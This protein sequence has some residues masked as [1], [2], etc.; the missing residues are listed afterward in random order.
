MLVQMQK[1]TQTKIEITILRIM[2]ET[3]VLKTVLETIIQIKHK[4][5]N[6]YNKLKPVDDFFTGFLIVSRI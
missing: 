2:L 3:T 4:K 6:L 1:T 5:N